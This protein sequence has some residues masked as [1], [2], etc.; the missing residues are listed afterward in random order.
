[1]APAETAAPG[2][3]RICRCCCFCAS[4]I[5]IRSVSIIM[6]RKRVTLELKTILKEKSDVLLVNLKIT[7]LSFAIPLLLKFAIS[8]GDTALVFLGILIPPEKI[9]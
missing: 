8:Y 6:G 2:P 9:N 4:S 7:A 1:M 3:R 5:P